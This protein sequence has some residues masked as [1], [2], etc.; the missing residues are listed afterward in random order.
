QAPTG[1]GTVGGANILNSVAG[2]GGKTVKLGRN[3]SRGGGGAGS[4]QQMADLVSDM[5]AGKVAVLLVHGANPAHSLPGAFSQAIAK[6]GFKV[7]F[8]PYLDE[9][10]AAADLILPDLHPLEQWHDA[11][12]RA[13]LFA[14]LQPVMQP[15]FPD[16]RHTGDVLLRASGRDQTFQEYLQ[17]TWR[18]LPRRHGGGKSLAAFSS[19]AWAHGG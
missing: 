4:F 2:R 7:G 10:A 19:E 17:G 6:V 8:S 13:G 14:L 12:P 11:R 3:D 16:A 5:E 9:T 15:V 1:A 18:E